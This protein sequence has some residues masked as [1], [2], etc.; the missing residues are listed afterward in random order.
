MIHF[1][2]IRDPGDLDRLISGIETDVALESAEDP[3]DQLPTPRISYFLVE[4]SFCPIVGHCLIIMVYIT[5]ENI[6]V[7][8]VLSEIS[9]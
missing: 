3:V 9:L 6:K 4:K 8:L 2:K 1:I 7:F 5:L